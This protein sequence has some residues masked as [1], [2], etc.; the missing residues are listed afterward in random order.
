MRRLHGA[1]GRAARRFVHRA[2]DEG[3]G[4]EHPHDRGA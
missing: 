3:A 2:R 1:G 4:Q